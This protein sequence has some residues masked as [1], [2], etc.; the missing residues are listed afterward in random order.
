MSKDIRGGSAKFGIQ[1]GPGGVP[2]LLNSNP[3]V[4]GAEWRRKKSQDVGTLTDVC[5]EKNLPEVELV[6]LLTE[7]LPNY[8]LRADYLTTFQGYQHQ[9][10]IV[11]FP[12]LSPDAGSDLS[13]V[14]IKETLD[15]FLLCGNRVSQMT[16]VYHDIQAVTKLLEEKEKDLELAAQIGQQLLGRNRALEEKIGSLETELSATSETVV[17]LRHQVQ[18]KSNLLEL[19]S[20]SDVDTDSE[21]VAIVMAVKGWLMNVVGSGQPAAVK[22][23]EIILQQKVKSLEEENSSLKVE[24]ETLQSQTNTM[25]EHER[26]LHDEMFKQLSDAFSQSRCLSEELASKVEE[27]ILLQE[28][29]TSLLAQL[30]TSQAKNRSMQT[31]VDDLTFMLDSAKETQTELTTELADLKDKY[32]EVLEL[33]HDTQEQVRRFERNSSGGMVNAWEPSAAILPW[34]TDPFGST[35][36]HEL[37]AA[38]LAAEIEESLAAEVHEECQQKMSD[39]IQKVFS[40]YKA[41]NQSKGSFLSNGESFG[42]LGQ[43]ISQP[44]A[45]LDNLRLPTFVSPVKTSASTGD[46]T[47]LSSGLPKGGIIPSLGCDSAWHSDTDVLSSDEAAVSD[48]IYAATSCVGVPGYPGSKD[49]KTALQKLN[50]AAIY[51]QRKLH[52]DSG[53]DDG[54]LSDADTGMGQSMCSSRFAGLSFSGSSHRGPNS[55]P[56]Y[57]ANSRRTPDSLMS[58][59]QSHGHS[60]TYRPWQMPEKLQLVKP[61]K[62]SVMLHNWAQMAVPHMGR[63]LEKEVGVAHK[64][65]LFQAPVTRQTS[66]ETV[67]TFSSASNEPGVGLGSLFDAPPAAAAAVA[68][69]PVK[70]TSESKTKTAFPEFMDFGGF[71]GR[72]F[73]PTH[74]T[75]KY[76]YSHIMHPDEN[77]QVTPSLQSA[78]MTV[79]DIGTPL[80]TPG[81]SRSH[82][83]RPSTCTFSTNLGIARVLKERGFENEPSRPG[84]LCCTPPRPASPSLLST[85]CNSPTHHSPEREGTKSGSG[86]Q[87]DLWEGL[88]SLSRKGAALFRRTLGGDSKD[89]V[90]ES[91]DLRRR[92]STRRSKRAD[93]TRQRTRSKIDPADI[94]SA[95]QA[96]QAKSRNELNAGQLSEIAS[97]GTLMTMHMLPSIGGHFLFPRK[98]MISPMAQLASITRDAMAPSLQKMALGSSPTSVKSRIAE[99]DEEDPE[100]EVKKSEVKKFFGIPRKPSSA[101]GIPV[102]P[103]PGALADRLHGTNVRPDLGKVGT[104]KRRPM[105]APSSPNHKEEEMGALSFL[106]FGR[107]GTNRAME[108]KEISIIDSVDLSTSLLGPVDKFYKRLYDPKNDLCFMFHSNRVCVI[109]LSRHHPLVVE[110]SPISKIDFRINHRTDRSLNKVS[111]KGKKGA[112]ILEENSRLCTIHTETKAVEL[113]AGIKGKLIEVNENLVKNP[114][115]IVTHPEAEGFI[116]IAMPVHLGSDL[117]DKGRL[118]DWLESDTQREINSSSSAVLVVLE[119]RKQAGVDIMEQ[120]VDG[121]AVKQEHASSVCAVEPEQAV[122]SA[123]K[124]EAINVQTKLE[125]QVVKTEFLQSS[126]SATSYDPSVQLLVAHATQPHDDGEDLLDLL[127]RVEPDEGEDSDSGIGNFSG[128]QSGKSKK[129]PSNARAPYKWQNPR[130]KNFRI[131]KKSP[132]VD[133][134]CELREESV[135]SDGKFR[136]LFGSGKNVGRA[137]YKHLKPFELPEAEAVYSIT[138]AMRTYHEDIEE[139]NE[140]AHQRPRVQLVAG[141]QQENRHIRELQR[142]NR[143]LRQSLEEHQNALDAIMSK[144]REQVL[145]LLQVNKAYK[146]TNTA[147][148]D[149]SKVMVEKY[150]DKMREMLLVM[151]QAM[152]VDDE[153]F[154][155][156]QE[157]IAR[158][159]TEN[160][161]L[162]ELL[163]ISERSGTLPP[164]SKKRALWREMQTQTDAGDVNLIPAKEAEPCP[165]CGHGAPHSLMNE[166]PCVSPHSALDVSFASSDTGSVDTVLLSPGRAEA[167]LDSS[168][169]PDTPDEKLTSTVAA[170]ILM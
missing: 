74:G 95:R 101:F 66:S 98:E 139:L 72:S 103:K 113:R 49:L 73:E 125:K 134:T 120:A 92:D 140:E 89:S 145:K 167:L 129:R 81:G 87:E 37:S 3:L 78:H 27:N 133:V 39:A 115:L 117:T 18:I 124:Q 108:N 84:S 169:S 63:V 128:R 28:E 4:A 146:P 131:P 61:M 29:I 51:E 104:G 77:T 135:H 40:T 62:G 45:L 168:S 123:V 69:S 154:P 86:L 132:Q 21:I 102:Q 148:H 122:A 162:R 110:R 106:T 38:S 47:Y 10:W 159:L 83:R 16:R 94:L 58:T 19:Y 157:L 99:A 71:P 44:N 32:S 155:K 130:L 1:D 149:H 20:M 67:V 15:Y 165:A 114:D 59:G 56:Y 48:D 90:S 111:G 14:V 163:N 65:L 118:L 55:Y 80:M 144:Y 8:K 13:P 156:Q 23:P 5:C 11:P 43:S 160:K 60:M 85:P 126:N 138:D 22:D 33:L 152:K 119:C 136:P 91:R 34:Q 127:N 31:E 6:S 64:A 105:P 147:V 142:E 107:K 88:V 68:F 24:A 30:V 26:Q 158:L 17:E 161:T 100:T 96:T 53:E 2:G 141:I 153:S 97:R 54:F 52:S 7:Q 75:Y 93:K 164:G 46:T 70:R 170:D 137:S 36:T 151:K 41:A 79:I 42:G 109:T 112:Q 12:A 35:F 116:A 50:P 82:S 76:I 121:Y 143:E 166:S 25:E 150:H 57:Q 9:D